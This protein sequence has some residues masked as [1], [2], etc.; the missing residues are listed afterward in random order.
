MEKA[1]SADIKED[2]RDLT[3]L[4]RRSGSGFRPR[5]LTTESSCRIQLLKLLRLSVK[6]LADLNGLSTADKPSTRAAGS[7]GR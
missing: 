3:E 1:L 7:E 5:S 2:A 4:R 6:V